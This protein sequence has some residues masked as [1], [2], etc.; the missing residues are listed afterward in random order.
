MDSNYQR[1][2]KETNK[3]KFFFNIIKFNLNLTY[4]N[5]RF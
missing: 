4:K 2:T 3:N 5:T 1:P